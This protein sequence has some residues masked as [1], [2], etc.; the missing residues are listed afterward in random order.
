ML[1][2]GIWILLE[3]WHL[4]PLLSPIFAVSVYTTTI[5]GCLIL[6][7]CVVGCFGAAQEKPSSII[8]SATMIILIFVCQVGVGV[9]SFLLYNSMSMSAYRVQMTEQAIVN[10]DGKNKVSSAIDKIQTRY[11]CC[12][13]NYYTDWKMNKFIQALNT[14]TPDS[15][16]ITPVPNCGRVDHPSNLNREGCSA[17]IQE[18]I[19]L[20]IALI[21]AMNIGFSIIQI[22][23]I[24]F[25]C[26]F[27]R[28]V[29]RSKRFK[30]RRSRY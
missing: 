14:S 4:S 3:K 28:Q 24:V 29:K 16:C 30:R 18:D 15:C 1:A 6:I 7:T 26:A 21:P 20:S 13:A 11:K 25:S 9:V 10:W 2:L 27:I 17:Y 8:A 5:T 19:Q 22:F 23:G 12:G